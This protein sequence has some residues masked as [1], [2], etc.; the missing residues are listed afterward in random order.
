MED[1][2][3]LVRTAL[4]TQHQKKHDK[5]ARLAA[6]AQLAAR[7][8]CVPALLSALDCAA[9]RGCS[10]SSHRAQ[11][12]LQLSTLAAPHVDA[13]GPSFAKLAGAQA[14]VLAALTTA[15][16]RARRRV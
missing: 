15:A 10:L 13:A 12:L 7:E 8:D 6:E 5:R 16:P 3:E 2:A 9:T 1:A 11:T 4:A 14:A